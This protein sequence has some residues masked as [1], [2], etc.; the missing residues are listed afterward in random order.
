MAIYKVRGIGTTGVVKDTPPFENPSNVWSD[1]NNVRFLKNSIAK[2]G[3]YL[4]IL[5]ENKPADQVPLAVLQRGNTDKVIYGTPDTLYQVEGLI[6]RPVSKQVNVAPEGDPEIWES[7]KYNAAPESTWYYTT[8]SNSV[9]MN[10]IADVP[11]GI[12]PFEDHFKDLPG[13]GFPAGPSGKEVTW[14]CGRIRAFKNY[15]I[16]LFMVEDGREFPQRVRWSNVSYVNDLPP[17][18]I[19]NDITKDGGFNDLSDS[20]GKIA[21][22][23]P[24][25]D[26]FIIYTDQETYVMDYIGGTLI[27]NFKKLYSDS[28][29]LA[30]ECAVEFEGKHFVISQD[31]IFV[32]N[33]SSRQPVAS[34]RVKEYLIDEISSVNPQA[35]KVIA[36]PHTKEIWICYVGPGATGED[37]QGWAAN[38]AAVWNW[39]FD[40]WSFYDLPR[41]YDINLALPPD[42]D[43]RDWSQYEELDRDEWEAVYREQEQWE[44]FGK[45]FVRKVL[46]VASQDECLYLLDEGA[47]IKTYD[48]NLP[49]ATDKD[50]VTTSPL[51][52]FVERT[53]LDFDDQIE[54][55]RSYKMIRGIIPQFQGTGMIEVYLGGSH[56][57]TAFPVW[58]ESYRFNIDED[59]KVDFRS[60]NRYPCVRFVDYSPGEWRFSGYDIDVLVSGSR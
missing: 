35:T 50:K 52:S 16:A 9:V 47:Y 3:G 51:V 14:R 36:L 43:T 40:T 42:T 33:G 55:S 58:D 15:L 22:G 29:I 26:S 7:V 6:H 23:L 12:T 37:N 46:W 39:E 20:I 34:G 2:M 45:D 60:T 13:W 49:G 54:N 38:R 27:F 4:P 56:N 1:A 30:P 32:H 44:S 5:L 31:D 10:N 28:G 21:D 25:R 8:L 57:S 53:H 17:D 48:K 24:L 19:E 41:S 18:W 59:N 11:Q